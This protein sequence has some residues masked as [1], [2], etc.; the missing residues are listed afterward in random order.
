M[1]RLEHIPGLLNIFA[2]AVFRNQIGEFLQEMAAQ[3]TA[4]SQVQPL[5][6]VSQASAAYP[7]FAFQQL[8]GKYACCIQL[9]L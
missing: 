6:I 9:R 8:S 3:S 7:A 5:P 2:D 1:L 4:V